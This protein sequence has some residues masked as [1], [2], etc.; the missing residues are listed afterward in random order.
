M[1]QFHLWLELLDD[2]YESDVP[3]I[4]AAV[5]VL[6][7]TVDERPWSYSSRHMVQVGCFG[8]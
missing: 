8:P 7:E 5:V 4:E 6:Q 1:H 3:T 2:T